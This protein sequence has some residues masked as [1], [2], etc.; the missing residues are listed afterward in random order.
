MRLA[1]LTRVSTF[2]VIFLWPG[3]LPFSLNSDDR[4]MHAN[5][6]HSACAQSYAA[7]LAI[8]RF[9]AMNIYVYEAACPKPTSEA[10]ERLV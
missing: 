5:T 7:V 8:S 9:I 1:G 3:V 10:D 4:H 6:S 2:W